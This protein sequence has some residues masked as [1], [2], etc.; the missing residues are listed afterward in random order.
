MRR[1]SVPLS[2]PEAGSTPA[3]MD[4]TSSQMVLRPVHGSG[5]VR[6]SA[7][8]LCPRTSRNTGGLHYRD[9][10]QDS[11]SPAEGRLLVNSVSEAE[12]WPPVVEVRR[13]LAAVVRCDERHR[14]LQ[15]G[16]TRHLA[17]QRRGRVRV[18]V[19]Q[20]VVPFGMRKVGV[21]ANTEINGKLLAHLPVV[22]NINAVVAARSGR[23]E[24]MLLVPAGRQPQQERR[25]A[26]A[27]GAHRTGARIRLQKGIAECEAA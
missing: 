13:S 25:E 2:L 1:W 9:A 24:G 21:P 15:I 11:I 14:A 10:V 8:A 20:P 27:Y 5:E 26:E 16:E 4:W 3:G 23:R 22:L 18:E 19:A 17:R 7:E 12:P 6:A